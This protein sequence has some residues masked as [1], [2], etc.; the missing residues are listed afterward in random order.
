M[1][2]GRQYYVQNDYQRATCRN[3]LIGIFLPF[4]KELPEY[5]TPCTLV[6]HNHIPDPVGV[7]SVTWG[8]L[9]SLSLR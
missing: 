3:D 9:S 5:L 6:L 4:V 8:V 7:A 2:A 1:V